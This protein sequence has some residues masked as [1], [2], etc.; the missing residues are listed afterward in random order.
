MMQEATNDIYLG[1]TTRLDVHRD[2]YWREAS[3]GQAA[4]DITTIPF[5]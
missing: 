2:C 3:M 1:W 5:G 4:E